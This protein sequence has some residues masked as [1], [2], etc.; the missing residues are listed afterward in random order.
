[1]ELGQA[2][3]QYFDAGFWQTV[4]ISLLV[5]AAAFVVMR[6][7]TRAVMLESQ[8]GASAVQSEAPT[9]LAQGSR[10]PPVTPLEIRVETLENAAVT[11]PQSDTFKHAQQGFR[12]AASC[13]AVAG[14][15]HA[16]SSTALLFYFGFY[17][18]PRTP[19]ALTTWACYI[20]VFWAWLFTTIVALALFHGPDRRLRALLVAGYAA[21]LLVM[22]ILLELAGAPKLPL[23]DVPIIGPELRELMLSFVRSIMGEAATAKPISFSPHTQ[24][25]LFFA[26]S[27][28]PIFL[29]VIGFNRFIRA[30]VGPLFI[31]VALLLMLGQ[32]AITDLVIATVPKSIIRQ[33]LGGSPY[34]AVMVSGFILAGALTCVVLVWTVRRYRQMKLSDQTFLFDV[35]WLSAS[36][37]VC[38]YLMGNEPRFSYLLGL[39]P[40]AFYKLILWYGFR[41]FVVSAR[42]LPNARLLFLRVFGSAARSEKLFDLLAARWRYAGSVQVISGTDIARSRFEPDEFLDFIA[43][44]FKTRYIENSADVAQRLAQIESRPDPDGRYRVHEFFCRADAWQETVTKLMQ[45]SELVAMD[46]RGFTSERRGCIFELGALMDHLPLERVVLLIDR[47][48][49]RPLLTQTL[50]S[51]WASMSPSSPNRGTAAGRVR[52]INL[53]RGYPRAV[54]RLMQ[55]GDAVLTEANST[56]GGEEKQLA[57]A[58]A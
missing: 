22:G 56:S 8:R 39:L 17:S 14:A 27:A 45:R 40:F 24:P 50:Q 20:G 30:T 18:P 21:M 9:A 53:T 7:Y 48:T 38:F 11:A 5:S 28:M 26:L 54:R 4:G 47:T 46:L 32:F 55:I 57:P 41:R 44:R 29:V 43:G 15:V 36:L 19:S 52:I 35:L 33:L 10:L 2:A 1:V 6:L 12:R 25:I 49:D 34:V 58:L 37:F 13:Y 16:A 51:V 31:A 3:A 42:P 23:N